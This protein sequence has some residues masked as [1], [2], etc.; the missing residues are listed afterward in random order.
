MVTLNTDFVFIQVKS[1]NLGNFCFAKR[2]CKRRYREVNPDL[3]S[4]LILSRKLESEL[5]RIR[6]RIDEERN[7]TKKAKMIKA[8]RKMAETLI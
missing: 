1:D 5:R 6:Q 3:E 2:V 4:E 7:R 8:Y